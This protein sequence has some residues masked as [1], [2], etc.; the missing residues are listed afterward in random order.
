MESMDRQKARGLIYH[1][2]FIIE[3]FDLDWAMK[4]KNAIVMLSSES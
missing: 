2:C 1:I 4:D 3:T